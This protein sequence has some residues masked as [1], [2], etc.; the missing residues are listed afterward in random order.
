MG[1]DF[2]EPGETPIDIKELQSLLN[3]PSSKLENFIVNNFSIMREPEPNRNYDYVEEVYDNPE[4]KEVLDCSYIVLNGSDFYSCIKDK[5][6]YFMIK[7][8]IG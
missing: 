6:I 1:N 8:M 2:S 4:G 7:I 5:F 3:I